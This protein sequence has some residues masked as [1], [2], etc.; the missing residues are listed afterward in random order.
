MP[1]WPDIW[2]RAKDLLPLV[3]LLAS[4][5][6]YTALVVVLL[7][8]PG[9]RKRWLLIGSRVLG[10]AAI[11][12]ITIVVPAVVFGL[13]V[14]MGGPPTETRIVRSQ[15]GQEAKLLYDAGFLGRD[16]TEVAL[17]T[18][19]CCRHTTVFWHGGPGSVDDVE[20]EWLDNHHLQL[21]YHARYGD[22]QHCER[23]VGDIT[24]V[25]KS[26]GWLN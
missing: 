1:C 16:Y 13:A 26:A 22:S 11:I 20:I 17:K 19:G 8:A 18:T 10:V 9:L 3:A 25:C 23:Q 7:W 4:A 24:V 14:A 2:Q 5:I 12:P 6:G 21:T 15:D